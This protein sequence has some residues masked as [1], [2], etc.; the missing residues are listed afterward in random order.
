M[1][2]AKEVDA[3]T[4][5]IDVPPVSAE[6]ITSTLDEQFVADSVA[7]ILMDLGSDGRER[8]AAAISGELQSLGDQY[9][10]DS[11]HAREIWEP[12]PR[13]DAVMRCRVCEI[14]AM[15][16][17]VADAICEELGEERPDGHVERAAR[18]MLTVAVN[19]CEHN[20]VHPGYI[21]AF[22]E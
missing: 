16:S 1:S 9:Q 17:S 6:A 4:R 2:K 13:A 15:V 14:D 10:S 21:V 19:C 3:G 18:R 8:V 20:Q 5:S 7:E 11:P 12:V 22:V